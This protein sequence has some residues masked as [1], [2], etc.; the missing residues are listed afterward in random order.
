VRTTLDGRAELRRAGTGIRA[1]RIDLEALRQRIT[2]QGPVRLQSSGNVFS[3][4]ALDLSLDTFEGFFDQPRYEFRGGANGQARRI[5][6]LGEQRLV[7]H[8]ATYTTCERDNEASWKP[9]W[10]FRA[11]SMYFDLDAEVG[12]AYKPVLRF[13]DVPICSGAAA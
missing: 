13:Q 2:T 6:F 1:D 4:S 5:D 9:A 10:E 12:Q 8:Q 11:E 3:G 7:A